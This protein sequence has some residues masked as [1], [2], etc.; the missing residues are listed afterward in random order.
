M[1]IGGHGSNRLMTPDMSLRTL[2]F[3]IS[4]SC[5]DV[6]QLQRYLAVAEVPCSCEA[7]CSR[8][9]QV[10][11]SLD[12][13]LHGNG[14]SDLC[15]VIAAGPATASIEGSFSHRISGDGIVV[16]ESEG[17]KHVYDSW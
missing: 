14:L 12:S 10:T 13:R 9:A 17:R 1:K 8:K 5:R 7:S 6:L 3:D 16:A 4:C 11:S 2:R 15:H